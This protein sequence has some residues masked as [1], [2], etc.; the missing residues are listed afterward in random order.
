MAKKLMILFVFLLLPVAIRAETAIVTITE[1]EYEYCACNLPNACKAKV[2]QTLIS[3]LA[4]RTEN[5][6]S[7]PQVQK[8]AEKYG[9][10]PDEEGNISIPVFS[11]YPADID[12]K[13]IAE[14]YGVPEYVVHSKRDLVTG[15]SELRLEI[16]KWKMEQK[17][18]EKE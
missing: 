17:Q 2:I 4:Q 12:L 6:Y 8:L 13:A 11:N 9:L 18:K 1:S 10:T 5:T 7:S 15:L 14:Q 16:S 3:E